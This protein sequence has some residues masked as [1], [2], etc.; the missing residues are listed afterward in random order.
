MTNNSL[1]EIEYNPETVQ[2][3]LEH[4]Q[5]IREEP[6]F[7]YILIDL[8]NA[9]CSDYLTGEQ[10]KLLFVRYNLELNVAQTLKL[11]NLDYKTYIDLLGSALVVL[12]QE[13]QSFHLYSEDV[14]APLTFTTL[15]GELEHRTANI[16]NL[17]C[18][19]ATHVLY[20]LGD[21]LIYNALG[22]TI[23]PREY[24]DDI[25]K[26]SKYIYKTKDFGGRKNATEDEFYRQDLKNNVFYGDDSLLIAE[27][28]KLG[29]V[30][31]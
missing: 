29:S 15:L 8:D 22:L 11:L 25:S 1:L 9:L 4:Y 27:L 24:T 28:D 23:D 18:T 3:L 21:T 6:K 19:D 31:Y 16:F 10:R 2:I 20:K 17:Q 13:C 7:L 12:S 14:V 5:K 30:Y 26:H